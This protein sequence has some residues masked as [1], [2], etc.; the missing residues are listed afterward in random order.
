[1]NK[2]PVLRGVNKI[3]G[4]V[5]VGIYRVRVGY[6]DTDQ[7]HVVHHATYLR[8]LEA[9]RVEYLRERGLDYRQLEMDKHLALPVVEARLR[10]HLPAR[11][12]DVL[13]LRTWVPSVSR[14]KL[15]FETLISRGSELLNTAEITLCCIDVKRQRL[16]SM[17][18]PLLRLA[19]DDPAR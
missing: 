1:V 5:A 18:E 3:P 9:A 2:I 8:Y 15:C 16:V 13:E 4:G 6:V 17:P 19:S 7:S 11:F 10:Y 12:D 14:A